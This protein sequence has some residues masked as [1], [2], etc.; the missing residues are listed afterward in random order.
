MF[1]DLDYK[2]KSVIGKNPV[3]YYTFF[4]KK[5]PF[6]QMAVSKKT[7]LC[8]EGFPRSGN[9]YAVVAFKLAN[10]E[11]KV[12]HHLHVPAQIKK[13]CLL[14][15]PCL[16][17][18]RNPLDAVS[19]FLVFQSSINADIYLSTYI[20]FYNSVKKNIEHILIASFETVISDLNLVIKEL[21]NFYDQKY[22][23]ID[24]IEQRQDEIFKKLTK[25]NDQFFKGENKKNMIPDVKRDEL[26]KKIMATVQESDKFIAA[27]E[28]YRGLLKKSI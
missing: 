4:A 20:D 18:I 19:S 27:E 3:I 22:R 12:G 6:D 23:L 1:K 11:I 26:K 2:I 16:V 25:I 9:S 13:A 28:I 8:I 14:N 17:I 7:E 10:P 15:I 21:N 24:N 5:Y